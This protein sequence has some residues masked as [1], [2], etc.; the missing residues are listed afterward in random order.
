MGKYYMYVMAMPVD[1]IQVVH[2]LEG[3]LVRNTGLFGASLPMLPPHHRSRTGSVFPTNAHQI[4]VGT[5]TLNSAY[6]GRKLH[7]YT[8]FFSGER[9]RDSLTEVYIRALLLGQDL[10]GYW[11]TICRYG[12][13]MW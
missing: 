2:S 6:Y 9:H 5:L 10:V 8:A 3:F 4:H 7:V 12:P 13:D 1:L 11:L